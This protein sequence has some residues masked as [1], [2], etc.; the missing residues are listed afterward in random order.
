MIINKIK[1]NNFAK[2]TIKKLPDSPGIYIFF[3][4]TQHPIYIGKSISLKKRIL[5][6]ISNNL[7]QKTR[8]MVNET[9]KF[10]YIAVGSEIESLL[11]EARLIRKYKPKY[12]SLHRDDKRPLYIK[13]TKEKY[14]RILTARKI[15][16]EDDNIAFYGPFPSSSNVRSVL[17]ILNNIFAYSDHKPQKKPCLRSQIGLCNPCPTLIENEKNAEKRK[18]LIKNYKQ[19]ISYIKGVLDGRIQTVRNRLEK[20]MKIVAKDL[21]FEEAVKIR[22]QI[23][24]LDYITQPITP[25]SHFIKNPNLLEDLRSEELNSLRKII[26]KYHQLPKKLHRIECFDV[27]HLSGTYPTASMV[28]FINGEPDKTFYRHFRISLPA[29]KAGQKK[30]FDDVASLKEVAKRRVKY[31]TKWGKPDLIV[32]DGGKSQVHQ[33]INV[34]KTHKICVIGTAKRSETL[35]IPDYKN[36]KVSYIKIKLKSGPSQNLVKRI[37]NEAHRFARRYH[38]HLLRNNLLKS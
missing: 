27:A 38:H 6:Y 13:I 29:G 30:G 17:R 37:R 15:E 22:D 12:N 28:T 25:I 18:S 20:K 9:V 5:T 19:N 26:S 10:S 2:E 35:I 14:P 8:K 21:S 34:F 23:S 1:K 7:L 4:E 16:K 36:R 33:F 24:K 11:L 3:N 32:V 31:L